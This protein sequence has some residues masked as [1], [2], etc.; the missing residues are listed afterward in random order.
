MSQPCFVASAVQS[1]S[2]LERSGIGNREI[3]ERL[4]IRIN[5]HNPAVGENVQ[6][7]MIAPIIWGS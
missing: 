7:H 6:E 5:V 4:G 2:L 1:S 3:L